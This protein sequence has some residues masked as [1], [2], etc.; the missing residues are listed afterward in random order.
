M[1]SDCTECGNALG[2]KGFVIFFHKKSGYVPLEFCSTRCYEEW[3][4]E[5][6]EVI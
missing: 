1:M 3:V 4:K 6:K 2:D 5:I